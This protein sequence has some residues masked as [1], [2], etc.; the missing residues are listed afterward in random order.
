M[1]FWDR[2]IRNHGLE[3][4]TISLLMQEFGM[5]GPLAG[6]SIPNGFFILGKIS[7]NQVEE[8]VTQA[9]GQ[10][11]LGKRS[12]AVSPFC[13]TNILTSAA[14]ATVA[15]V[16]SY[17]ASGGGLKGLNQAFSGVMIALIASQPIGK[18]IQQRFTTS[19]D[20][21]HLRVGEIKQYQLGPITLHWINTSVFTGP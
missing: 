8:A 14:L 19:P 1:N 13:G 10:L 2:T 11:L 16:T 7:F 4:A 17:K 18:I 15:S 20:M 5:S 9:F 3:H 21:A 6:Y 12:L